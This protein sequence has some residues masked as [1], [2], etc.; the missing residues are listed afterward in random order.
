PL[1]DSDGGNQSPLAPGE[2]VP[3]TDSR[4]QAT[5]ID[6]SWSPALDPQGDSVWYDVILYESDSTSGQQIAENITDTTFSAQNLRANTAYFWQ[7]IARDQNDNVTSG[8]VWS[9]RTAGSAQNRILF[10]RNVGS[11]YEIF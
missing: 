2:P 9:F 5:T 1:S 11:N 6:L 3:A 8:P 10:A 4:E 7:V